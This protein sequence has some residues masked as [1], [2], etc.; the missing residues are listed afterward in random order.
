LRHPAIF[1]RAGKIQVFAKRHKITNLVHFHQKASFGSKVDQAEKNRK[2]RHGRVAST[3]SSAA[4]RG[5]ELLH[6]IDGLVQ[7]PAEVITKATLSSFA[8]FGKCRSLIKFMAGLNPSILGG[9]A[10]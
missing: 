1:R 10:L 8:P 4:S 5:G 3:K 7:R 6:Q 9:A 2:R